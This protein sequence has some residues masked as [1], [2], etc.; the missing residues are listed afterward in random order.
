MI[1]SSILSDSF[2]HD[3]VKQLADESG[4]SEDDDIDTFLHPSWVFNPMVKC[5]SPLP[6]SPACFAPNQTLMVIILTGL[7]IFVFEPRHEISNNVL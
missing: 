7:E 5:L 4:S 2:L 6:P 3:D 1:I